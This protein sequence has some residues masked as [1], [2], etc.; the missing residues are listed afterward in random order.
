MRRY[1]KRTM[2]LAVSLIAVVALLDAKV[3]AAILTTK[4]SARTKS[5]R[6]VFRVLSS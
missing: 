2:L 3:A 1:F 5:L 6:R 4:I